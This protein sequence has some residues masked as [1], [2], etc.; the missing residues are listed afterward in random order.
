MSFKIAVWNANGLSQH[1]TE[2]TQFLLDNQIDILLVSETHF[3]NKS[4]LRI[5]NHTIYHTTHPA[6][7]AR[8]GTAVI[9]KNSIKHEPQL[10]F[11][12]DY[13]QATSVMV[14][15][16]QGPIVIT[17]IYCPPRH[18]IRSDQFDDFFQTLS[19]RFLVGGD[20]NAKHYLWGSRTINPKGRNLF[21]SLQTNK[22]SHLSTGEPTYWPTDMSK[23]PDVI[24]FC[25]TKGIPPH[26]VNAKSSLELSS[27]HSPIIISLNIPLQSKLNPPKLHN[28]NTNWELF[29]SLVDCNLQ[30]DLPLQCCSDIENAVEYFTKIIQNAG[31]FSTPIINPNRRPPP[32]DDNIKMKIVQKRRLRKTWQETRHPLDKKLLNKANKELR[33]KLNQKEQEATAKYLSKLTA[34]NSTNYSLWKS[35][36]SISQPTQRIPPL[37]DFKGSWAKTNSEKVQVFAEHFSKVFEPYQSQD[38]INDNEIEKFLHSA[39]QLDFPISSFTYHDVKNAISKLNIKK[40]PGYDLITGKILKE[41]PPTGVRVLTH[42]FN[43]TLRHSYFPRQWKFAE[44]K[45]IPKPGKPLEQVTSYRPISLLP[46][47]SKMLEKLFLSKLQPVLTL[48]NLI[49]N[50]QFGFRQK[51]S[52]IEQVHRVY[53]QLRFALE[54]KKYCTAAY[55]DITQAFDKVWH[56]GLLYKLKMMLPYP[57]FM[58]LNSYLSERSFR[59][60]HNDEISEII[61]INAGVPQGSVLGPVLYSLFTA[62][63]PVSTTTT[64][65][66]FA[67]DTVIMSTHTDPVKA[68]ENL[69]THILKIEAWLKQW[70]IKANATKSIQ[71]TYTLNKSTCPPVTLNNVSMAQSDSAKY[72]GIHLDRRLTWQ[73][74]IFTKRKQL[75]L[76]LTSLNHLIGKDS[77]MSI[78]N[79]ILIYKAI[80]KPIWTYG[81]QLW[82]TA[83]KSNIAI[84]ER[85]QSKTLRQITNAPRCVTNAAILRDLCI[86]SVHDEIRKHASNYSRRLLNH[87]NI[88]ALELAGPT[89]HPRRLK[90]AVPNDLFS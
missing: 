80:V 40:S 22:L 2:V 38:V 30:S 59:I 73:Q 77:Q 19:N 74:H 89:T 24:D 29:R 67:D 78:D 20:F 71:V 72:L 28:Q 68:S 82:G 8:G 65:A 90:K 23:T 27:D 76:K 14:N 25:V 35:V 54:N 15:D 51:H 33:I 61:P 10:E 48:K 66:T 45:V 50:H 7:T 11:R 1:S 53:N 31:W 13:I 5:K 75:G 37:K 70:R 12:T 63:L 46:V 60:N 84:M 55:L 88:L 41:L 36:K 81:I 87:P 16:H 26:C 9:I 49:P 57:F 44:L 39:G 47:L 62:D 56:T 43:A 52:T 18:L 21:K 6:G 3:T 4:F 69:Q 79:K 34:T 86:S 85:F 83:A 42:I 32:T 17:S 58:F 64:T